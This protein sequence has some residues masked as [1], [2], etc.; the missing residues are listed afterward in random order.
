MSNV[1]TMLALLAAL[2]VLALAAAFVVGWARGLR[3]FLDR[4]PR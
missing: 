1:L 2:P 4:G 3:E